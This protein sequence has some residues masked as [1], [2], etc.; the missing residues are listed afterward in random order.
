MT[1]RSN[2]SVNVMRRVRFVHTIRPLLSSAAGACVLLGLSLYLLGR[3]VF[4]GQ[5]LRNIPVADPAAVLRFVESAFLNTS[6]VVQ[7]LTVLAMLAGLWLVR[8]CIRLAR[9]AS[10]LQRSSFSHQ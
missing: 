4:V 7:V 8:E 9:E 10:S 1:S 6:F 5:I 2:L 3:E